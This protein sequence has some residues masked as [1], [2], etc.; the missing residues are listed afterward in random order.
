MNIDI[1]IGKKSVI[2]ELTI[3]LEIINWTTIAGLSSINDEQSPYF[4][5]VYWLTLTEEEKMNVPRSS[6][7]M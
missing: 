4:S 2:M 7:K 3:F 6:L 1:N 5:M